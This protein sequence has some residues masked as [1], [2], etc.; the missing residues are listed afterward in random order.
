MKIPEISPFLGPKSVWGPRFRRWNSGDPPFLA[1]KDSGLIRHFCQNRQNCGVGQ[2]KS[3][4]LGSPGHFLTIFDLIFD[5]SKGPFSSKTPFFDP[6]NRKFHEKSHF[7][8]SKSTFLTPKRDPPGWPPFLDPKIDDFWPPKLM[9]FDPQK[10]TPL[11][12]PPFLTLFGTPFFYK[13]PLINGLENGHFLTPNRQNLRVPPGKSDF[14]SFIGTGYARCAKSEKIDP[15]SKF[16]L[17]DGP[18][19]KLTIFDPQNWWFWDPPFLDP[20]IDDF[21]PPKLMIFDPQ[22]GTP[23]A[24]PLKLTIFWPPFE[25]YAPYMDP[26]K[27]H[28]LPPNRQNLRVP[29]G[30]LVIFENFPVKIPKRK[31]QKST[32]PENFISEVDPLVGPPFFGPPKLMVGTPLFWTPKLMADPPF[33]DPPMGTPFWRPILASNRSTFD[34]PK[35]TIFDPQNGWPPPSFW[36]RPP[37]PFPGLWNL[38]VNSFEDGA[39]LKFHIFQKWAWAAGHPIKKH[40]QA[41]ECR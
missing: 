4:I 20:K 33:L 18:P 36:F 2:G 7:L 23:L 29:P 14:L 40:A 15:P 21:W 3:S 41:P 35:L 1:K 6:K 27:W 37:K 5:P 24:D 32:P 11:A 25:L 31:W 34:P 28:F 12:D 30:K 19:S 26:K 9:I 8:T 17:R 13:N 22:K 10:G 16:H 39:K 38:M